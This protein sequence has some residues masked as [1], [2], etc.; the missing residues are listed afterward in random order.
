MCIIIIKPAGVALPE[1]STLEMCE[2]QNPHGFGF[3]TPTKVYHS[4]NRLD[5][6]NHVYSD[7]KVDEPAIIHCR[8]ATHGSVRKRNCHPFVDAE[9][10][11][12]FAHN[13]ILDL[14]P[15]G[16]WTDSETAFRTRFVP[17]IK[18]YGYDS[19]ELAAAVR[20]TI[21]SSRFAFLNKRGEI[22]MYGSWVKSEGCFF[23]HPV[24]YYLQNV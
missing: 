15:I 19:R 5:F 3:A 10:G 24:W 20:E 1:L 2:Y 7:I 18:K 6:E 23:S 14:K 13:G 21:G 17:V 8:I 4:M 22:Q 16:D 9:T 11:V 12:A